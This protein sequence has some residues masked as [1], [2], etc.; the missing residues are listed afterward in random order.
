MGEVPSQGMLSD[1]NTAPV[2]ESDDHKANITRVFF[3]DIVEGM[4]SEGL[5]EIK[6]SLDVLYLNP[7]NMEEHVNAAA[8]RSIT[9]GH[10]GNMLHFLD[11]YH[12]AALRPRHKGVRK[13]LRAMS[14]RLK[15]NAPLST[16]G[17]PY[18][19]FDLR[20]FGRDMVQFLTAFHRVLS[21]STSNAER[22]TEL[23]WF[24]RGVKK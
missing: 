24:C 17:E 13:V 8:C 12:D 7:G 1:L 21:V 2:A 5:G 20:E 16:V 4:L 14:T 18:A 9:L 19:G 11:P 6:R 15:G 22:N 23:R 10:V 3:G